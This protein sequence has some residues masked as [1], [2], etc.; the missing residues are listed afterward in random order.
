MSEISVVVV[1]LLERDQ[2]DCLPALRADEFDDYE[3]IIRRDSGVSTARNE[4]VKRASAD[5]IVFLDDDAIPCEGY[6]SAVSET[7]DDH[8]AVTGKITHPN[9]DVIS[10][11][12]SKGYYYGDDCRYVSRVTGANMAFR[13]EVF[14]TVGY[15][16]ENFDWGHEEYDFAKRVLYEYPIFYDPD[17]AVTHPYAESVLDYWKKQYRFGPADVYRERK[18]GTS[19]E[20][21][22]LD[23]AVDF[24][25][26]RAYLHPTVRGTLV[27]SVGHLARSVSRARALF[28]RFGSTSAD[29]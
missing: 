11:L 12:C 14:E 10:H 9:D 23:V 6:L 2:I 15:F 19:P 13:R 3:V 21:Q 16:D 22:L 28:R 29:A 8:A 25:S 20:R 17:V 5:K 7:L 26:P 1:T 4:G 24:V 18:N 27:K